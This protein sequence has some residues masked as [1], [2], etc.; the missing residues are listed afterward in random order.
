MIVCVT[1]SPA[2][3]RSARVARFTTGRVLRPSALV[4]LPGGK[5]VN[6]AR[7]ARA[8]GAIVVTTGYAGGHAG[9][10]IVGSLAAEGLNPRF[11]PTPAEARTTY[12]LVDD[13]GRTL[14][15]Y[16]PAPAVPGSDRARLADLLAGELLPAAD[17]VVLAG[18][19]PSGMGPDAAAELVGLCHRADRPCLVDMTGADLMAALAARPDVVK[20][21]LEEAEA[22][23][24]ARG[25]GA[26]AARAAAIELRAL[27]AR[28]AVV[29]DGARGVVGV[30][31]DDAWHVSVP[32][33]EVVSAVGSGDGVSAGI[34][35]GLAA[36]RAF[37]DAIA[38][39][40]AAGTANA[41]SLGAGRLTVDDY[42][43]VLAEVRVRRSGGGTRREHGPA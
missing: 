38:M 29:T 20:I 33:I 18:S 39:G 19:L 30:E 28:R 3:D 23:G 34:A 27:G 21:S 35:I 25:R 4:V 14:L 5:G 40:A 9:D 12:V 7:V 43:A 41:R 15:V 17:F 42:E 22:A 31:R 16:E 26:S 13:R 24:L 6:V 10:W 2:V 1:P 36:G 37:P 8:L 11:V 32:S